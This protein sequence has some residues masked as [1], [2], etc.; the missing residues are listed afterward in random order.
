MSAAT[1]G[2][3][4]FWDIS[5]IIVDYVRGRR[6]FAE[7]SS[8][9]AEGSGD[10]S[11]TLRSELESCEVTTKRC[12]NRTNNCSSDLSDGSSGAL[13]RTGSD[14]RSGESRC[15]PLQMAAP[16]CTVKAH[17]SG[18]STMDLCHLDGRFS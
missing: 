8:S 15:P 2:N 14:R 10:E 1:D 17:Q 5:D 11:E 18:V 6:K 9:T 7:L 16:V 12:T 3:V 4:A 13:N